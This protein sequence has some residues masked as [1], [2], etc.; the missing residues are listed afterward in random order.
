MIANIITKIRRYGLYIGKV[1][2][3]NK[4]RNRAPIIFGHCF[5]F[6]WRCSGLVVGGVVGNFIYN[7][8]FLNQKNN[9]LFIFI[10]SLPFIYD[11]GKQFI[12][13]K[14]STNAIRTI[15]GMFFGIALANFRPI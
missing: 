3:C 7:V 9:M 11:M 6:C 5:I 14:E 12:L 15:T 13:R 8:G 1:P 4:N 10:L 2:I